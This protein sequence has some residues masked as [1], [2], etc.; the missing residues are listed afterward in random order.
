MWPNSSIEPMNTVKY[1]VIR[2]SSIGDI[3]LTTPVVRMLKQQVENAE[4][5]YLTKAKFLSLVDS[6]PYVDKVHALEDNMSAII[7]TLQ[8]EG[9]DYVIDL[10]RNL[11][12]MRVKRALHRMSFTF[13]KL[14]WKKWL[15]VRFKLNKMPDLHIVDRYLETTKLF[16]VQN[17]KQGLDYFFSADYTPSLKL[18]PDFSSGYLVA[19][20]GANHATK[21]MPNETLIH[22]L[23]KAGKPVLLIGGDAEKE[24]ADAIVRDL[25]VPVSNQCGQLS[26]D[27]SA[28]AIQNSKLVL[29]PDTG[30][31]HIAAALS[32]PVISVWGN[33]T[34]ELGMYPY[35]PGERHKYYIAEVKDLSCRPCSKIGFEKCP[36]GHF[37]C[38]KK[39]D[40]DAIVSQINLF[41]NKYE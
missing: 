13:N 29:T 33:T 16:D 39:Q 3:V 25:N 26:I 31:M 11:R 38:M 41:W 7:N 17:D 1:L 10:H 15:Y 6:N 37:D 35:M 32:K 2:F 36:K 20:L 22:V 5:H 27:G 21:Q 24:N 40:T 12:S 19:V 30:M 4:V 23:N 28:G 9:Y 18:P 8:D 34:P 14:N